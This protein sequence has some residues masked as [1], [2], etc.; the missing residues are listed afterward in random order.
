MDRELVDGFFFIDEREVSIFATLAYANFFG[1]IDPRIE[2]ANSGEDPE[3][4]V[5]A[6]GSMVL[7]RSTCS[8]RD[9]A[10]AQSVPRRGFDAPGRDM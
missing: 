2:L 10:R 8:R 3:T 5:L 6:A 9:R 1:H 4:L 7:S